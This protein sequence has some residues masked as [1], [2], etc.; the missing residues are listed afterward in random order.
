MFSPNYWRVLCSAS[1]QTRT[2][3]CCYVAAAAAGSYSERSSSS[4]GDRRAPPNSWRP[5]VLAPNYWRSCVPQTSF[6]TLGGP[7]FKTTNYWR[8]C[9]PPRTDT[10]RFRENAQSDF[11][12]SRQSD[13]AHR[14]APP[15]RAA[16]KKLR[17]V[18]RA[19]VPVIVFRVFWLIQ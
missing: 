13:R 19:Y 2:D 17:S 11:D 5:C 12:E 7:V 1:T 18:F 3:C 4:N 8:S 16:R 6:S 10:R 14:P 9:V 15:R